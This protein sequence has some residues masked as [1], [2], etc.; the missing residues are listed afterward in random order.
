MLK[1]T[2]QTKK[3][4]HYGKSNVIEL[5]DLVPSHD[6]LTEFIRRGFKM[7]LQNAILIELEVLMG[8]PQTE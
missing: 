1:P 2:Y 6:P 5:Q 7:L 3:I 4:R 8:I